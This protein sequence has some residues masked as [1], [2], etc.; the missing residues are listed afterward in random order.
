MPMTVV[1]IL[2][3]TPVLDVQSRIEETIRGGRLILVNQQQSTEWISPAVYILVETRRSF[4]DTI[5]LLML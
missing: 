5:T 1:V 2:L 4:I 3:T